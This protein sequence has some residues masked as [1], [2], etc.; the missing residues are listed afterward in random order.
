M[1]FSWQGKVLVVDDNFLNRT[2]LSTNLTEQGLTVETAVN[3]VQALVKLRDQ[4]FD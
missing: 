3:G 2:L 1:N 4:P